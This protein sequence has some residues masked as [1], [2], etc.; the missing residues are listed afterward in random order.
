VY[1]GKDPR[2]GV[3]QG[4]KADETPFVMTEALGAMVAWMAGDRTAASAVVKLGFEPMMPLVEH[5]D[6]Y[7]EICI[8]QKYGRMGSVNSSHASNT[9]D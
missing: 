4:G 5:I 6:C 9:H 3:R 2:T 8:L 7:P 1:G